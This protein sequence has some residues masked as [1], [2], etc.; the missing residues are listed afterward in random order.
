VRTIAATLTLLAVVT[1]T[2]AVAANPRSER[3]RLRP[4]DVALAKRAVLR[5]A[6]VGPDWVRVATTRKTDSQFACS[7]FRPDFS[8]FTVTGQASA[9]FRS[10]PPGAQMDSTV[11]IFQTRAQAAGDFRRGAKPQLAACL[12]DQVRR[13]FRSYPKGVRG[14][15]LSSKMV[16][17]PAV[18]EL[19]AAYAIAAELTGNGNSVPVFVDVIAMQQGRSIAAMVFTGVGSRLPSKQYYAASVSE[20]L[21]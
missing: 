14:R 16:K 2:A 5:Q 15:L 11:A 8:S 3:V 19:S 18:G 1:T 7:S 10:S 4:A 20:R 12:A 9:S 21:R 17:A 6:D 13:A